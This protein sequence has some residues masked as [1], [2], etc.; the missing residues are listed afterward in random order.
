VIRSYSSWRTRLTLGEKPEAGSG[1]APTSNGSLS[2]QRH[3]GMY[4]GVVLVVLS[5]AI[6]FI[7]VGISESRY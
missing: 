3:T 2:D 6:Q 7:L 4:H 1:N 5:K